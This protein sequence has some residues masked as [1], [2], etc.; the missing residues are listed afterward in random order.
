M[1][2]GRVSAVVVT[3]D[4]SELLRL[5]LASLEEQTRAPDEVVIADDGSAPSHVA[6]IERLIAR[7]PLKIVYARQ[8]HDGYRAAA[9]RNNG[10]R[11]SSGDYLFFLDGD[12]VLFPDVLARHLRAA[13]HRRWVR[14]FV[15]RLTGDESLRVSEAAIRARRLGELWPAPADARC[16]A[17]AKSAR[18]F[19]LNLLRA[20]LWP[21]EK[22]K[23]KLNL[24]G[25][26]ASMP[27][28]AFERVN[29]F[30]ENYRGWGSDD[31]D[32]GLRLQ[33]AGVRGRMVRPVRCALHLYHPPAPAIPQ[34]REYFERPRHGEYRCT[35][36]LR[37]EGGLPPRATR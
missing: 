37:Q 2:N 6:G 9:N 4:N 26:Q 1:R 20:W 16:V 11:H 10:V 19:R 22:R 29:G 25:G 18:H 28:E 13:G 17:L 33:L 24:L 14:G 35:H 30:D 8:E 31:L 23:R 3:Y 7:S 21:S 12:V 36:G 15:I 34:S 32:L 5:C 27:R